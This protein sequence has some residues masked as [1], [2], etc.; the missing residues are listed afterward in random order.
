MEIAYH[1]HYFDV[2]IVILYI[3]NH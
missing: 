3:T 1:S 2:Y